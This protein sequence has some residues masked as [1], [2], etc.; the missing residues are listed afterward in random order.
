[1]AVT[2]SVTTQMNYAKNDCNLPSCIN[3]GE[4]Y[5]TLNNSN[6]DDSL[7]ARCWVGDGIS[8]ACKITKVTLNSANLKLRSS[9]GGYAVVGL[10]GSVLLS[11]G[12]AYGSVSGT[13]ITTSGGVAI[14]DDGSSAYKSIN[15]ND[16]SS[17]GF[18]NCVCTPQASLT[19]NNAKFAIANKTYIGVRVQF[20][21]SDHCRAY[22]KDIKIT[23]ERTRACYIT[24]KGDNVTETKTMYDYGTVPA[25][26]STPTRDGY[27]FKGWS[28]GTTTYSGTLPTAYEQD[29]TYTAVWEKNKVPCVVYDSIFSFSMW[30]TN[31]IS[32]GNA[33]VSN[34]TETGFTLKSNAG[35]VEGTAPSHFF[36]VEPGKS[37]KIDIDITGSNWDVYIFFCDANGAWVD[38]SDTT[39]RFS[40]DGSG[41]SSRIFTAPNKSS[42]VKAQIR[43]DANGASNTVSFANFRIY[44]A[45]CE[46]MS[47]SVSASERTDIGSWS[48]P[49]PTRAGYTFLGWNTKPDGSG[50]TYTA[51][52]G[53]PSTDL[54]LYS[55]WKLQP[56]KIISAAITYGGAQVSA[57]NKVP[58]GEG[59]L[60]AVGIK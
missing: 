22:I 21:S 57:Q 26:G 35:A 9:S 36:S 14:F 52:S 4:D 49:T 19:G 43:V 59:Y 55:Q 3:G 60:I 33:T 5:R 47:N 37:Y 24:F 29:V 18:E 39:N 16:Y 41:V 50:V 12:L 17:S 45:D 20:K 28:N 13:V 58:A 11:F 1:M 23:V 38:F 51:S 6:T 48:M 40:F 27:T 2:T 53:F 15:R 42:V 54:V 30:K 32:A 56:P 46:Y 10:S 44:P 7:F 34:I 25:Y 8:E 31:G